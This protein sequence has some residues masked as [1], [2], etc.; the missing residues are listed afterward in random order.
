MDVDYLAQII[1]D[2]NPTLPVPEKV[3]KA[4]YLYTI[5]IVQAENLPAL[6]TNGFS[7]P[8]CVLTDEKN[9]KL[10]QTRVIYETLN[11]RWD[12]AF[13]ITIEETD[14]MRWLGVTVWDRDQVGA[15]DVCGKAYIR[16]DPNYFNDFLA[17]DVWLD[18]D[19]HGRILLRIS[20]EGEKDDIQFYFGKA[21]RTL[22]RAHDDMARTIVDRVSIYEL[23]FYL[24]LD[25]R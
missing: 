7:D 24:L 1:R 3:E 14:K 12:E 23:V 6:D 20:M 15:D 16:L 2:S 18:L 21:F 11:P 4:R 10:V 8:Y 5:K 25:K 19:P 22:K 13:D 9:I 17:H